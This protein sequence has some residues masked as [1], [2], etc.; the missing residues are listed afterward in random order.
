[1]AGG[2]QPDLLVGVGD[3]VAVSS[4]TPTRPANDNL[5]NAFAVAGAAFT[6]TGTNVFATKEPGE[7]NH[8]GSPGGRSVW[9]TW[10]AP[11]TGKAMVTTAGSRVD[12]LLAVYTGSTIAGLVLVGANDDFV[13]FTSRVRFD[14]VAGT[15][16]RIAVDGFSGS[17][18]AIT[19]SGGMAPVN[20]DF[21]ERLTLAPA[22]TGGNGSNV[23][24]TKESGE[25]NHAGNAGGRSIWWSWT[26][27]ASGTVTL[28][29]AGSLASGGGPL[30]TLLAVYTG[31]VARP[32]SP[33]A[34]APPN[35]LTQVAANDDEVAGSILTSRVTFPA[36]F[37]TA[38][39]IVVDGFGGASGSV[40]F[41]LT[42]VV[43]PP[44][45][46][47][48]D[49]TVTEGNSRHVDGDLHGLPGRADDADGHGQLRH[50]QWHGDRGHRLR[51]GAA[52]GRHPDS[53]PDEPSRLRHRERRHHARARRDLLRD[54]EQ[55][56][57]RD[58]R[59]RPRPGNRHHP[60]RRRRGCRST[61]C[62]WWSR[63]PARG[64]PSSRSR[65]RRPWRA[66]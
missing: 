50:Q 29:T 30:D 57:E 35:C 45:L 66:P 8:A 1:M 3:A 42:E 34:I 54:L 55:P 26:A 18:G 63:P 64:T 58:L 6:T 13:D 33:P 51:R 41:G 9:W 62:P 10:T 46:S 11:Q 61:T 59:G 37:G 4:A 47:I 31:N 2:G 48:S 25:P 43:T 16:Y 12:T 27:P 19:L 65:C 5:A 36:S 21:A 44:S 39:R 60:E 32:C 53:G 38:Y 56:R 23:N 7:P 40:T 17:A 28:T 15:A 24:A 49:A 20:D 22:A 14:A 52:H